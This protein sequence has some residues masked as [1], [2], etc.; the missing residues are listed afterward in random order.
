[1]LHLCLKS[2]ASALLSARGMRHVPRHFPSSQ[3][4]VSCLSPGLG[5]QME[6][7]HSKRDLLHGHSPD[8]AFPR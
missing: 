7:I 6:N 4:P 5:L 8:T 2:Q 1:M 3:D